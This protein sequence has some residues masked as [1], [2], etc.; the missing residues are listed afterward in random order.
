MGLNVLFVCTGNVCRSPMAEAMLG[1]W[2]S[3]SAGVRVSSAGTHALVG[4]PIDHSSASA[5]ERL[6]IDPSG[7]D[8]RQYEMW[9]AREAELVLTAE[10]AHRDHVLTELPS[11]LRRTFTM[12]EFA[13]LARRLERGEPANVL[14]QAARLRGVDGDVGD[15]DDIPD[16][17]RAGVERALV[18]AREIAGCV[19][20]TMHVLCL[21]APAAARRPSPHRAAT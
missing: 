8:A 4:E 19:R 15:A 14:E 11:A 12:K 1:A 2:A 21:D 3:A 16:P 18:I 10:R 5:L 7:H 6:G 17:F 13:R 9:M 20:A